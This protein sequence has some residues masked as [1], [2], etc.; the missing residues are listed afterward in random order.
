MEPVSIGT[1]KL[2]P[3]LIL[4]YP[5]LRSKLIRPSPASST[6]GFG[7][8]TP[9]FSW[10]LVIPLEEKEATASKL[11]ESDPTPIT[12]IR[13]PGLSVEPGTGPSLPIADTTMTPLAVSSS[14]LSLKGLS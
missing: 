7:I 5:K 9:L 2:V 3:W 11:E 14:I 6:S 12:L 1:A 8:P 4:H 13:S 10:F